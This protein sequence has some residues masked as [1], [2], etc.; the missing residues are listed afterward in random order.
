MWLLTSEMLA[1]LSV[2]REWKMKKSWQ[3]LATIAIFLVAAYVAAGERESGSVRLLQSIDEGKTWQS[4]P[5][6]GNDLVLI[7]EDDF[8]QS[9]KQGVLLQG[10]GALFRQGRIPKRSTDGG[11]SWRVMPIRNVVLGTMPTFLSLDPQDRQIIYA[12]GGSGVPRISMDSG[13]TWRELF[14]VS[15]VMVEP[16]GRQPTPS[17]VNAR[18]V[19]PDQASKGSGMLFTEGQYIYQFHQYGREVR[20]LPAL[21]LDDFESLRALYAGPKGSLVVEV[22]YLPDV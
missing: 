10:E 20:R 5:K 7:W 1:Y 22:V 4:Y 15:E 6:T 9:H 13:E 17:S 21:P 14:S 2:V 11:K 3:F 8:W 16:G 19:L 18:V 12:A